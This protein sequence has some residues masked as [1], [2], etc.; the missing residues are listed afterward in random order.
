MYMYYER[1][2][3]LLHTT[4]EKNLKKQYLVLHK[5]LLVRASTILS[6]ASKSAGLPELTKKPIAWR[7]R[8]WD[9]VRRVFDEANSI[10]LWLFSLDTIW[11]LILKNEIKNDFYKNS[12][13]RFRFSLPRAFQWW[14]RN[15]HSSFGFSGDWFFV[16]F[17]WGS[18]PAVPNFARFVVT[19]VPSNTQPQKIFL[20]WRAGFPHFGLQNNLVSI[21][22]VSQKPFDKVENRGD[23]RK[24]EFCYECTS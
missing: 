19:H 22:L 13:T 3:S 9:P 5:L 10:L 15:C 17:Y 4:F 16:H 2:F 11:K 14:S 24:D 12:Q 7:R 18:N 23:T 20:V 1:N 6:S 8:I 21:R